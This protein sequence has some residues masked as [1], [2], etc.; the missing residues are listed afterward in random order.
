M[1]MGGLIPVKIKNY[2]GWSPIFEDNSSFL[3][4]FEDNNLRKCKQ[5]NGLSQLRSKANGSI[6]GFG[7]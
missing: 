7:E 2:N 5:K 4:F 3:F 1:V 6:I